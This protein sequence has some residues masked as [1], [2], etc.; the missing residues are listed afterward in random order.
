MSKCLVHIE[1]GTGKH[2]MAAAVM[3][4]LRKKYDEI[5]TVSA[6][7]DILQACPYV[8]QSFAIGQSNLYTDLVCDDDCTVLWKDPYNNNAFIKKHIHLFTAWCEEFAIEPP[9]NPM[10]LSPC[11]ELNRLPFLERGLA[12]MDEWINSANG[13]YIIVQFTGGQSPLSPTEIYQAYNEPI[14]RNYYEGQKLVYALQEAYPSAKILCYGLPN[15]PD[16]RGADKIEVPYLCYRHAAK[17]AR[18]IVCID[19]S[20]QHLAAGTGADCTVIWGETRPEHFGYAF[21]KNICAGNVKNTQPYFRPLGASPSIV[22][23]PSVEVVMEV[24]TE[25]D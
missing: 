2:I 11:L 24:V 20:L 7:T 14:K 15:E 10:R 18:K 19:S 1:G 5:Y 9:V 6:Y 17:N 16:Y 22:K 4:L 13:D 25:G 23:F 3:P 12:R 8:E 21:H